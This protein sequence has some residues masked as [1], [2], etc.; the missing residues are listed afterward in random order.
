LLDPANATAD[1][2]AVRRSHGR[3]ALA[4]PWSNLVRKQAERGE[5]T[6]CGAARTMKSEPLRDMARVHRIAGP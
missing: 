1:A 5:S 3:T 2:D 6:A 4:A